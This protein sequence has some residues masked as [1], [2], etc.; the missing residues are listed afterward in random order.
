MPKT[1]NSLCGPFVAILAVGLMIL[2]LWTRFPLPSFAIF[3][4]A[5]LG[6]LI[7]LV[8]RYRLRQKSPWDFVAFGIGG[9]ALAWTLAEL[10]FPH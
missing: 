3:G 2:K 8:S 7:S 1:V 9:L 10:L 6:A 4:C 5:F